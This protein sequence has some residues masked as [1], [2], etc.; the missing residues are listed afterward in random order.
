MG[1]YIRLIRMTDEGRK[2]LGEGE[3][4]F[5]EFQRIIRDNGGTLVN[6]W[7][8]LGRYDF[9]AVL[10]AP[11]DKTM[12]KISASLAATGTLTAETLPAIPT[13]QMVEEMG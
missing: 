13:Q 6:S 5:R 11:D 10:E 7:A 4:L 3:A 9:V 8:T 2:R 12:L 1:T